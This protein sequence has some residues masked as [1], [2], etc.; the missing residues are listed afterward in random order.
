METTAH[1]LSHV[2]ADAAGL[3]AVGAPRTLPVAALFTLSEAGRKASLLAGGDGRGQQR[4]TVQVPTTRLHL[5]TVDAQGVARLKLSPR[6]ERGED[7]RVVRHAGPPAYD[8]PPSLDDLFRDASRNHELERLY[9]AE[10]ADVRHR[11]RDDDVDRRR[12]LAETF[13]G[14]PAQRAMERPAPSTR[15]CFL[16]T[17]RGRVMFDATSDVGQARE[18]P[19]E[20]YR[21]FRV[22]VA[23]QHARNRQTRAQQEALG[24]EKRQ[25]IADWVT[26]H[27]TDDQ[28]ARHAAGLLPA[29]EVIGALT[30]EAFA[31]VADQPHYVAQGAPALQAHL[32]RL[33]GQTDLVV[34][35]LD[36][37]VEG[38]Q[39]KA[40]TA[41][42]WATIEHLQH[43]LP[44]ARVTLREHR[45]SWRR[46]SSLP[47]LSVFGVLVSRRIGPF[48]LRREFAV[49]ER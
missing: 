22:D 8:L 47:G 4:L 18:V 28:R 37:T 48:N 27:G 34:A 24:A 38:T 30:D 5:V 2:T 36:L 43:A 12:I 41:P 21:R 10:R 16:A 15:R 42:Q 26:A 3:H 32:R 14:D 23:A 7:H 25:V 39:A 45:L 31:A 20:A 6:F 35:P 19:A 9:Q 40:A 49:P 33:T 1:A 44:D 17:D 29:D 13:F 11:R 46:D